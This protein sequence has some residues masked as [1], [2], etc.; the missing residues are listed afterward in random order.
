MSGFDPAWLALREPYD[1]AV[2]DPG[3]TNAFVEALGPAPALL[4]LGCGAG[5][6]LRYLA[7]RLS[8]DQR[9]ICIDY[10]PALLAVLEEKKPNG[11]EVK[12]MCLDL[13]ASLDAVP[14]EPGMG[15]T[16]AALLDL[17]SAAWLDRLA[18]RCRDNPVL[19]T[20][21]F[22]GR[23]AWH[24]VDP[25]DQ[26]LCSAFLRHQRGDKGFGPSLGA[27]AATYLAGRFRA[28][29]RDVRL[30][31]SDWAFGAADHPIQKA[32]LEGIASAAGEIDPDFAF[33]SWT[34][35]RHGQIQESALCL[36]VGHL[37]LLA[38]PA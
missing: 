17:T 3:L 25:G 7:P 13:A 23:M 5:S 35:R 18:E 29:G 10:D 32:M 12:T 4:D 38:L 16:A 28:M 9:W 6:N 15:V 31:A 21:S 11:V 14:I 20:L 27:D 34:A 24:P 26:R 1:H 8:T 37:D 22:D 30:A 19:I 2:R 36:T 33:E